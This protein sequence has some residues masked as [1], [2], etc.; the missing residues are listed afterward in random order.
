[1]VPAGTRLGHRENHGEKTEAR[2]QFRS[3]LSTACGNL[4]K[5]YTTIVCLVPPRDGIISRQ[6]GQEAQ[7]DESLGGPTCKACA[8]FLSLLSLVGRGIG[9]GK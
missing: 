4:L 3:V 2:K 9:R 1:M 6:E 5:H 7:A 8:H